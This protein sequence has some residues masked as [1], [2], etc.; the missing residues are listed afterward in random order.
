M[1]VHSIICYNDFVVVNLA[2]GKIILFQCTV[3]ASDKFTWKVMR[4]DQTGLLQL[5]SI[6]VVCI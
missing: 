5:F 4:T 3:L 2:T 1:L 6:C